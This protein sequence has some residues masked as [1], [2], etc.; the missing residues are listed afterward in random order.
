MCYHQQVL[1]RIITLYLTSIYI[2]RRPQ[3]SRASLHQPVVCPT[4][5]TPSL[6]PK[7]FL[8][9]RLS[10]AVTWGIPLLYIRTTIK[11]SI[12]FVHARCVYMYIYIYI[13]TMGILASPPFPSYVA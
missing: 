4:P 6:P 8:I 5:F 9:K 3:L 1:K 12:F 2:H 10:D 7:T 13:S 11:M